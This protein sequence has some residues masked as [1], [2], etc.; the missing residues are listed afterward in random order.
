[1][2]IE[3]NIKILPCNLIKGKLENYVLD[4]FMDSVKGKCFEDIGYVLNTNKLV[5]VIDNVITDVDSDILFRVELDI[6]NLKPEKDDVYLSEII[7]ICENGILV[8][9]EK[10]Q[11]V[12]LPTKIM[13]KYKFDYNTN[14]FINNE[15][16]SKLNVGDKIQ[17]KIE[18]VRYHIN[19]FSCF[20]SII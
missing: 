17:I 19:S 4:S 20:G 1:M 13:K 10:C 6:D 7:M 15:D 18:G 2:I 8:E 9:V 12:L 14:S 3:R 11:K 16:N 5:R